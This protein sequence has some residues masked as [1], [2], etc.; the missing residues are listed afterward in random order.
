MKVIEQ[1]NN[2]ARD[3]LEI[4]DPLYV[5]THTTTLVPVGG[6]KQLTRLS[7]LG[8]SQPQGG[9]IMVPNPDIKIYRDTR[10]VLSTLSILPSTSCISVLVFLSRP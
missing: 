10:G 4:I 8:L 1:M 2:E 3:I 5:L 9:N 6:M 7:S